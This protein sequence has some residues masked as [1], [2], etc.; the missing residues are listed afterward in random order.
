MMQVGAIRKKKKRE[1]KIYTLNAQSKPEDFV[2]VDMEL[3]GR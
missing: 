2:D 1:P 3:F